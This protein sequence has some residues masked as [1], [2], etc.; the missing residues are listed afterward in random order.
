MNILIRSIADRAFD[1]MAAPRISSAPASVGELVQQI[2]REFMA[3]PPLVLHL[4]V[5]SVFAG[6]WA[7]LRESTL[8]GDTD[9]AMREAIVSTVSLLNQCPFCV[10][11]HTAAMS[12][13]GADA[14]AKAVRAGRLDAIERDEIRAASRWA[15]ATLSPGSADLRPSPFAPSDQ[16]YAIGTA[17][18]FHYINRMVNAFLKPWP[19]ALPSFI[20]RRGFMTRVNA[21]FPGYWL[22]VPTLKPGLSLKFC[23]KTRSVPELARLEGRPAVAQAWSAL[24]GAADDAGAAVLSGAARASIAEK[25]RAWDGSDPGLGSEWTRDV[26]GALK[27]EERAAATFALTCALAAYRIDGRLVAEVRKTKPTDTELVSIAA[28]ASVQATCRIASWL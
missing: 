25:I 6:V 14:A 26:A 3:G 18:A 5:P 24:V 22:G 13:L 1:R 17:L 8:A 11:S 16:P 19:F 20:K 2:E 9:R 7:A 4:P 15:A 12:A 10:D 27:Q 28:W 21:V 23:Q